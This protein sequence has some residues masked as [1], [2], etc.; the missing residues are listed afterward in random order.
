[1]RHER[2]DLRKDEIPRKWYNI[3]PD[4][5][6]RFPSYRDDETGNEIRWLPETFT[7]TVSKLEFSEDRWID[8]PEAVVSNYIHRGRPTPLIRAHRLE[9]FLRTSARIYY[10]CEDL[11]PGGT[12]KTNTAIPQAYWAMKEGYSRTIIGGGAATRTKFLH[13]SAAKTFGLTPTIFM[14]REEC[15]QNKDQVFFLRKMFEADLVESPSN[16]TETGRRFLSD[17]PNH[18]GSMTIRDQEIA[19]VAKQSEDAVAVM[20]SFLNHVLMTQTIIGLE[21][22]HQLKLADET[23]DILVASVGS[24]SHFFGVIAPFMKQYLKKNL[25]AKF[26]AV[27]AETSSKLTNGVY[28]F[29]TRQGPLSGVSVK[30]YQLEW[31]MPPLPIMGMGI[32]TQNTA[33]LLSF[34][35]HMGVI[36]TRVYPKDEKSICDAASM[37]LRTEGRLLAPESAYT[38]R[39]V[40]DEALEAKKRSE[41]PVIAASVSGVAYMDFGEKRGYTGIP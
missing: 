26:L 28:G 21:I 10:K 27:E 24:G 13:A 20:S 12:F 33:P 30:A 6:E 38:I 35:R 23:P 29:T 11:P 32:H 3:L 39:A 14:T 9:K 17:N 2:I 37:F 34:L 25:E 4:L 36:D 19:E 18:P 7:K 40:I 1:M 31:K 41:T 8:I 22:E 16:R 5:P 15:L